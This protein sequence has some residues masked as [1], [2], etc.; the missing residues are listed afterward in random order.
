MS[1]VSLISTILVLFIGIIFHFRTKEKKQSYYIFLMTI[2]SEFIWNLGT[3]IGNSNYA[4]LY[5]NL[6]YM[7]VFFVVLGISILPIMILLTGRIFKDIVV[8]FS[9][10]DYMR[11]ALS[12]LTILLFISN[13]FHHLIFKYVYSFNNYEWGIYFVI[14][15]L[16]S[17]FFSVLPGIWY[18]IYYS[19]RNSDNSSGQAVL[20]TIGTMV[21]VMANI[22]CILAKFFNAQ[23]PQPFYTFE[24][25]PISFAITLVFY[26]WAILK[27]GFM[28]S[29]PIAT[30]TI[31]NQMT[32]GFL[33]IN[34]EYK[35]SKFNAPFKNKFGTIIDFDIKSS[36]KDIL[37]RY[38]FLNE[39]NK[40]FDKIINHTIKYSKTVT[41]EKV[42]INTGDF[43]RIFDIDFVPL[44]NGKKKRA[45][46]NNQKIN[47]GTILLFKDITE[48]TLNHEKLKQQEK[49]SILGKLIGGIAHSFKSPILSMFNYTEDIQIAVSAINEISNENLSPDIKEQ[50]NKI[51]ESADITIKYI[52]NMEDT[53]TAI[54]SHIESED[55]ILRSE[56]FTVFEFID[57]INSYGYMC[58]FKIDARENYIVDGGNKPILVLVFDTLINNSIFAY[59]E[60]KKEAIIYINIAKKNNNIEFILRDEAGGIPKNVAERIFEEVNTTKGTQGTGLGLILSKAL[61]TACF[62]GSDL[63]FNTRENDGTTWTISIPISDNIDTNI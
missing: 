48:Q 33:V 50:L 42:H 49:L 36:I 44:N 28:D 43:D 3:T 11:F 58:D 31:T 53:I 45:N 61:L 19:I 7:S 29:A 25:M 62:R 37:I 9:I 15:I 2:I 54:M 8:K 55:I 34:E 52:K 12:G 17:Y 46:L 22:L 59:N 51:N 63:T 18:M 60:L 40:N 38:E 41:L 20:L 4:S 6:Q 39:I 23:L 27:Y 57:S 10:L 14:Y 1:Y 24:A 30:D 26:V 35:I 13:D 21:Y 47:I 56:S 32:D 5:S 16:F